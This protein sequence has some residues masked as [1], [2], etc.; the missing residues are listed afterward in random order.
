MGSLY[1]RFRRSISRFWSPVGV[2]MTTLTGLGVLG[3]LGAGVFASF[4]W[5]PLLKRLCG[6]STLDSES[7]S[8]LRFS[9]CDWM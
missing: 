2:G 3:S 9:E 6:A 4:G 7:G 5:V 1:S 8:D